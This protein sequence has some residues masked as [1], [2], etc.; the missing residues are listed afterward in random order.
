MM[1]NKGTPRPTERPRVKPKFDL[2]IYRNMTIVRRCNE[3]NN[4]LRVVG[5]IAP[6]SVVVDVVT[7][8]VG[9]GLVTGLLTSEKKFITHMFLLF[10]SFYL[11]EQ[12]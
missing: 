8:S 2:A 1:I 4:Y 6:A 3:V 12:L 11:H 7:G 10:S 9:G 5:A